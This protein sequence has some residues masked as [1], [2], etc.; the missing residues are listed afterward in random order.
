MCSHVHFCPCFV[1]FVFVSAF[2]P[3]GEIISVKIPPGKNC[4][5][6]DFRDQTCASNA[7]QYV[8]GTQVGNLKVRV[9][10]GKKAASRM[11]AAVAPLLMQNPAAMGYFHGYPTDP[12]A[13]YSMQMAADPYHMSNQAAAAMHMPHAAAAQYMMPYATMSH[14][15]PVVQ[16][17]APV[18][19]LMSAQPTPATLPV[20]NSEY[21]P[22]AA[23]NDFRNFNVQKANAL[24]VQEREDMLPPAIQM[25]ASS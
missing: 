22:Y 15:M 4:G 8:N 2:A 17:T 21:A 18:V 13:A 19:P 9:T 16:H 7:I 25:E 3:Y 23:M 10:W 6:V 5:F 11:A 12:Y 1:L 20:D 14:H 24:Y